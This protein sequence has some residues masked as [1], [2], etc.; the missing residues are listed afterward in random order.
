[1][2][3]ADFICIQIN[4]DYARNLNRTDFRKPD[5]KSA[6]AL[7]VE[8][9]RHAQNIVDMPGGITTAERELAKAWAIAYNEVIGHPWIGQDERLEPEKKNRLFER[10]HQIYKEAKQ[11]SLFTFTDTPFSLIHAEFMNPELG[12]PDWFRSCVN[13]MIV[14]T[15]AA[16]EDLIR[17]LYKDAT[18]LEPARFH[19]RKGRRKAFSDSFSV[20]APSLANSMVD[21]R[22]DT[23]ALLRN[24]IAH[25]SGVIT[26][27]SVF[28]DLVTEQPSAGPYVQ[29]ILSGSD[30]MQIP[31][32][33]TL[34]NRWINGFCDAAWHLIGE[35][36]ILP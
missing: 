22:L 17:T 13:A 29:E 24:A 33:A 4:Q 27:I 36:D 19:T 1:M 5:V 20:T 32:Q 8:S 6:A 28:S 3:V 12:L 7:F 31:T 18:G 26:E 10:Y 30:G 11:G 15:W 21:Y 35:F 9:L 34:M 23:F 14:Y 2:D 16:F 25:N